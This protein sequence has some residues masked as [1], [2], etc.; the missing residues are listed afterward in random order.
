MN[1]LKQQS[2]KA[3]IYDEIEEYEEAIDFLTNELNENP[4]DSI[5]LN[6]RGLAFWEIGKNDKALEDLTKAYKI[7]PNDSSIQYCYNGLIEHIE[8]LKNE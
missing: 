1:T 4:L 3:L 7:N 6:N 2:Y 8:N 5:L